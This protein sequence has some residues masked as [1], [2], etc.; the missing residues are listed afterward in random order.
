[1]KEEDEKELEL[2]KYSRWELKEFTNCCS[3]TEFE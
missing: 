2:D 3:L 1:M